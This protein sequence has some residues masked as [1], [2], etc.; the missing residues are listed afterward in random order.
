MRTAAFL[1]LYL[2]GCSRS[3]V[4]P[5]PTKG[6]APSTADEVIVAKWILD[7]ADDPGSVE[8]AKWGTAKRNEYKSVWDFKDA[9]V[10]RALY[11]EKNKAGA[12]VRKDK[13]FHIDDKNELIHDEQNAAEDRWIEAGR[14]WMETLKKIKAGNS[15]PDDL[16]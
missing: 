5:F 11:R 3:V 1:A 12:L 4:A 15:R 7:H 16:P 14:E 10:V 9:R 2:A 6:A 13:L 8:F